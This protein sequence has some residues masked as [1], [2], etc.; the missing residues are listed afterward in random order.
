MIIRP[1]GESVEKTMN[2]PQKFGI[3]TGFE[4]LDQTILGLRPSHLVTVAGVSGIGKSSFMADLAI[5]GAREVPVAMFSLEM[6]TDLMYD[7]LVC[8]F[9]DINYH[10]KVLGELSP[11]DLRDLN[12]ASKAIEKLNDIVIDHES[13]TMYPSWIRKKDDAPENSLELAIEKYYNQYGCR[14]FFIDYVQIVNYGFK[15]ESETLRVKALTG[16]LHKL[17]LQFDVPIVIFAQLKKE[18]GDVKHVNEN[19]PSMT[20]IRDSGFIINDSDIILLLHR[21]EYFESRLDEIDLFQQRSEDAEIIVAK[22]RNG[23]TGSVHCKFHGYSMKWVDENY[24][25]NSDLGV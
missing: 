25:F 23:M 20:D 5:A 13:D 8:N 3:R 6:G 2:E 15:T 9:A 10:N 17:C 22:N 4:K 1:N 21:P 14:L 19:R 18:V 16:T 12:K 11:Q 24:D 7:R